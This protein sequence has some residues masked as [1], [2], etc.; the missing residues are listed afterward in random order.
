MDISRYSSP[1]GEKY[2]LH[3]PWRDG[4]KI[5]A[6]D[7]HILIVAGAALF[8]DADCSGGL[9]YPDYK[10]VMKF[11]DFRPFPADEMSSLLKS[12][13]PRED[14]CAE[15]NGTGWHWC[16]CGNK[17]D[18]GGCHGAGKIPRTTSVQI[19][20]AW[21]DYKYLSLIHDA[22]IAFPGEWQISINGAFE[23]AG[24]KREGIEIALMPIRK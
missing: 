8:P 1:D 4:E 15:C 13:E 3:K 2:A 9:K 6:T 23:A 14:E 16:S 11:R 17:H 12:A 19:P 5:V 10:S 20:P 7:G 18:C 24:F 22:M 21:F